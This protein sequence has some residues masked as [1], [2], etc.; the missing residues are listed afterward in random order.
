MSLAL[1]DAGYLSAA[2]CEC[3]TGMLVMNLV[4]K[5]HEKH[6]EDMCFPE[7]EHDILKRKAEKES[8]FL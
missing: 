3:S 6:Q 4:R 1:W 7:K 2:Q 8:S 5:V